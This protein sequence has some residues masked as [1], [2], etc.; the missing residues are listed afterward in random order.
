MVFVG[1]CMLLHR[2]DVWSVVSNCVRWLTLTSETPC[3]S[4]GCSSCPRCG[5]TRAAGCVLL[6]C[7][8]TGVTLWSRSSGCLWS[9]GFTHSDW[10]QQ[11]HYTSW[12]QWTPEPDRLVRLST[13]A[14]ISVNMVIGTAAFICGS[15]QS[16][17]N[18][19][20]GREQR[21]DAK[22]AGRQMKWRGEE[23]EGGHWGALWVSKADGEVY[24]WNWCF[25]VSWQITGRH[26]YR[27]S[28]LKDIYSAY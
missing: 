7:N 28:D 20:G 13:G 26:A 11:Q 10:Q 22:I 14:F 17:D 18:W 9:V 15:P 4:G 5:G 6:G 8:Q 23:K 27:W 3:L 1:L 16:V 12:R 25:C 21:G 2:A 24:G 19:W